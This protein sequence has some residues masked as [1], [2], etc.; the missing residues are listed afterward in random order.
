MKKQP[1]KPSQT[2]KLLSEKPI[3]MKTKSMSEM[4]KLMNA[5]AIPAAK[6]NRK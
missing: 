3:V 1:L 2:A 5:K 6:A 4:G